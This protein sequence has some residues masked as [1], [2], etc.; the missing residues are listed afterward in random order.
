MYFSFGV[1]SG[2][3]SN[4]QIRLLTSTDNK[5]I[6]STNDAG[7]IGTSDHSTS[8][9]DGE[10]AHVAVTRSG[11]TIYLFQN[12]TLLASASFSHNLIDPNPYYIGKDIGAANNFNGHIDEFRVILGKCKYAY[13]FSVETSAYSDST[14]I[15]GVGGGNGGKGVSPGLAA[16]AGGSGGGGA[17]GAVPQ[18]LE[19]LTK[20]S[21]VVMVLLEQT[22]ADEA[23]EAVAQ[24]L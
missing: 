11:N 5:L 14:S 2:G 13:N 23:A 15:A 3:T 16:G 17:F 10:F 1:S 18:V 24:V 7:V 21:L 22:Q 9:P 12:G 20:A 19:Q 8:L 4:Q 6:I